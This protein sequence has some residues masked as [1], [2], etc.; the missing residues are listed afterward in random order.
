MPALVGR[1]PG[2]PSLPVGAVAVRGNSGTATTTQRDSVAVTGHRFA[3]T[4]EQ[5]SRPRHSVTETVSV[6]RV[7]SVLSLA[8]TTLTGK[9]HNGAVTETVALSPAWRWTVRALRG[10]YALSGGQD[11]VGCALPCGEDQWPDPVTLG[12]PDRC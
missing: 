6:G 4:V 1:T 7:A 11:L 3:L 12:H 9:R 10:Q 8:T 5:L 2:S